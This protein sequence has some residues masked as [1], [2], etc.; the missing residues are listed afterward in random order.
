[1]FFF[2]KNLQKEQ[3]INVK[4]IFFASDFRRFQYQLDRHWQKNY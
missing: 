3:V 1:M 4:G 2:P